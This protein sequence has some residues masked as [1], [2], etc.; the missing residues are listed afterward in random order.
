MVVIVVVGESVV[1]AACLVI[2]PRWAKIDSVMGHGHDPPVR[3]PRIWF[4]LPRGTGASLASA[5]AGTLAWWMR[6]GGV[7]ESEERAGRG[8]DHSGVG[9]SEEITMA[10][11]TVDALN[12]TAL[13]SCY[14]EI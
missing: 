14:M 1:R 6:T 5:S 13:R 9:D 10:R 8:D 12:G 7:A 11:D 2:T 3:G 4:R